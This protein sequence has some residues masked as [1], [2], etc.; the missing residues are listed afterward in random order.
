M[1]QPLRLASLLAILAFPILEIGLL[2][3]AGQSMGFWRLA[4]IVIAT[5]MLGSAVIRRTGLSVLTRARAQMERGGRSFNPLFDGLLQVTA[6]VLLIFPGLISDV[7]GLVLLV[8][9]VRHVLVAHVLPRMFTVATYTAEAAHR[10]RAPTRCISNQAPGPP[11]HSMHREKAASRSKASTSGSAKNPSNR[12][13][14]AATSAQ[15]LGAMTNSRGCR[16]L[17]ARLRRDSDRA[18]FSRA[19]MKTVPPRLTLG[20]YK[21]GRKRKRC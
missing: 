17:R 2:I 15:A 4:L 9:A 12:T 21:H 1:A 5:A 6:G 19:A 7:L 14:L 18:T 20:R 10:T 8:P 13:G 11:A 16:S 3:R